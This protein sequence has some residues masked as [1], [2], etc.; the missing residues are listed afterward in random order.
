MN[1][2]TARGL[3][4][5]LA[6]LCAVAFA[7]VPAQSAPENPRVSNVTVSPNRVDAG[8]SPVTGT[9]T[10]DRAPTNNVSVALHSSNSQAATVPSSIVIAKGQ[11]RA[12][13]PVTIGKPSATITTGISAMYGGSTRAANLV[14]Q[15]A[16]VPKVVSVNISTKIVSPGAIVAV[17]IKL[18]TLAPAGGQ[19]VTLTYS[20]GSVVTG[21]A[22]VIVPERAVATEAMVKA[23]SPTHQTTVVIK[24]QTNQDSATATLTVKGTATITPTKASIYPSR[25]KATETG[26]LRI[27]L[28]DPAPSGGLTI[29]LAAADTHALSVQAT[30]RV[31]AGETSVQVSVSAQMTAKS[32]TT[33]VT[34]TLSGVSVRADV[35]I[36]GTK[37]E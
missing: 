19:P 26:T 16:L 2:I 14:V 25:L 36:I 5:V 9:V 18:N 17:L 6:A 15:V 3:L 29:N 7:S 21:P 33:H 13:F 22:S 4:A 27:E 31:T 12:T 24:A 28:S 30:A 8:S 11:T 10:L 32:G 20:P 23:G 34:A 1:Q 37:Q 35:D